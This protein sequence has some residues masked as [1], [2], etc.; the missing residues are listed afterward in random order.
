MLVYPDFTKEFIVASD[1]SDFAV[2]AQ[3]VS[4]TCRQHV[5]DTQHRQEV[6]ANRHRRHVAFEVG[7]WVLLSTRHLSLPGS[8]RK[9]S[10]RFVGPYQVIACVGSVA[11]ML[12]LPSQMH[13]F[14]VFHVSVRRPYHGAPPTRPS[15]D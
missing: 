7:Q 6:S 3:H 14:P 13:L 2:G 4:N 1:A 15:P 9:L 10:N 8:V 5:L 11:Y 12:D